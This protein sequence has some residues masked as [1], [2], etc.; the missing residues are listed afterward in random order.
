MSGNGCVCV[1]VC[2]KRRETD[3]DWGKISSE[4]G[5]GGS[6]RGDIVANMYARFDVNEYECVC[7]CMCNMSG[8]EYV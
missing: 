8:S 3:E 4:R 6:E 5:G 1:C 7:V 2:V